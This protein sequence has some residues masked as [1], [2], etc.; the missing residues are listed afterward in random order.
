MRWTSQVHFSKWGWAMGDGNILGLLF[1]ISADPSRAQEALADFE[2]RTGK[3]FETVAV[4][5]KPFNDALLTSR[6]ST[7]L[8]SEELGLHL[9]RAVTSAMSEIMPE[10]GRM[11]T[12]LLGVFAVEE[13]VKFSGYMKK[14]G[15]EITGVA[16]ATRMM[17]EAVR[18]NDRAMEQYAK[19]HIDYARQQVPLLNQ[20]VEQQQAVVDSLQQ[21]IDGMGQAQPV[22][23]GISRITGLLTGKQKDLKEATE[24]LTAIE[25]L[26]AAMVKILAEDEDKAQKDAAR[27]AREL[28]AEQAAQEKAAARAAMDRIH[29][30]MEAGKALKELDKDQKA[31][32]KGAQELA[33]DELALALNLEAYGIVAER[34]FRGQIN[35]TLPVINVAIERTVHLSAARKEL[36]GITQSLREVEDAFAKAIH[37]ETDALMG[38]TQSAAGIGEQ[39]AMLVGSKKAEAEVRGAFDVAMSIE[40]MAKFIASWGTDTAA[41]AAS[42]QYGLAA[43]EM[44]KVAGAGGGRAAGGTG[45]YGGPS[46]RMASYGGEGPGGGRGAEAGGRGGG[47][48]GS[49]AGAGAFH[50]SVY[51][52]MMTD[53]NST[54]QFFDEWSAAT[55]DGSLWL[56]SSSTAIQ[57]P[58]ATGRG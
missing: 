49:G 7:R 58:T 45:S 15:D 19:R 3:A 26:R 4:A 48:G 54:Q 44:F 30:I 55:K 39:I 35:A 37:G 57:G 9:P 28:V 27:H 33:K 14:V 50:L 10:I 52:N 20:Q 16:E 25:Q 1:E 13:L 42:V 32:A 23:L 2:K 43:A 29:I 36:I 40:E 8:L 6:E 41:L 31:A 18:E 17:A 12:A 21:E 51:G 11:G 22:L 24:K 56:T 46:A 34:D 38:M 5:P 47:S 53:K